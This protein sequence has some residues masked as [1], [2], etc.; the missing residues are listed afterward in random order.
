MEAA[1]EG[2]PGPER[3]AAE[4]VGL[5]EMEP[6]PDLSSTRFTLANPGVEYLTL[7]PEPG[8]FTVTLEPASY[9]VEWFG[10][11]RRDTVDAEDVTVD[12]AGPVDF[13]PPLDTEPSVL[14]PRST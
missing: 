6:R 12:V 1:Q 11:D 13:R 10:V 3:V 8:A 5:I 14:Y 7:Q 4:R 2:L 9:S